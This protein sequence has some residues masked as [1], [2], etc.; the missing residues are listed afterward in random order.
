M[1]LRSGDGEG[2]SVTGD[3]LSVTG[4]VPGWSFKKGTGSEGADEGWD[5][6]ASEH[7]GFT[8][9][10]GDEEVS[11]S[12]AELTDGEKGKLRLKFRLKGTLASLAS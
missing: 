6:G 11:A 5:C 9:G 10:A 3:G 1:E 4:D 8:S 7:S 12:D 2:V